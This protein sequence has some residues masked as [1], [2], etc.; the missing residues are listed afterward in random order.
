MTTPIAVH[1]TLN[2]RKWAALTLFHQLFPLKQN[3]QR[4]RYYIRYL[5]ITDIWIHHSSRSGRLASA[6]LRIFLSGFKSYLLPFII[7]ALIKGKLAKHEAHQ[8]RTIQNSCQLFWSHHAVY[9]DMYLKEIEFV[10]LIN[11]ITLLV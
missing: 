11:Y 4:H 2:S 10:F 3:F 7:K 1:Q 6:R 9:C 5:K 8:T